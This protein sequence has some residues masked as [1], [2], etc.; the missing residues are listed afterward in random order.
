MRGHGLMQSI[1]RVNRVY[2]DKP[3]GLIVDYLGIA[4]DLQEAMANYTR[5]GGRQ[6]PAQNQAQAVALMKTNHER[7]R[8]FFHTLDYSKFFDGTPAERLAVI[9]R[10]MEHVLQQQDGKKRYMDAVTRLSKAFALSMPDQ[11]ALDIRDDVA[12]FQAVRA[13][14]AKHTPVDG[15]SR[16]DMEG[17]IKQLVSRAVA[18]DE[19]INI[20]DAAGIKTTDVSILSDE[21]LS[22]IHAME[23]K[24]LALELLRKLLQDEIRARARTNLVQ[25]RS[26]EQLLEDALLRYTNRTIDA[27][28][29]IGELVH[30][31][32]DIREA[33]QRGEKLGLATEELAFYDALADNESAVEVMG[34]ETL[35][36]I[37]RELVRQVR[38]NVTIDWTVR[39]SARARI[40]LIVKRILRKHGY[41]PDLQAKATATV[42]EQA[43]LLAAEWA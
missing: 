8:H 21:F 15:K 43:E 22:E 37:A 36:I 38:K 10:A 16:E 9:P 29:V 5:S 25:A 18:S 13:S 35:A 4:T 30:L 11:A 1:A 39:Q 6:L 2:Q 34:D 17:A 42:L 32:K 19:V 24:N 7:V 26:F 20:F 28:E 31:A 41:P 27:T 3:G 12:F 14:F 23:H 33:G 40:R